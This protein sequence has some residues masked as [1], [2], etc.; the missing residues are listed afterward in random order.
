MTRRT[1]PAAMALGE[2][3][4]LVNS[5]REKK[6]ARGRRLGRTYKA[7]VANT[8]K[9][10]ILLARLSW[11]RDSMAMG[12]ANTKTSP[13]V[14]NALVEMTRGALAAPHDPSGGGTRAGL[15]CCQKKAGGKLE[16]GQQVLR[17]NGWRFDVPLE[18][19]RK[20]GREEP[21]DGVEQHGVPRVLEPHHPQREDPLVEEEDGQ[22]DEEVGDE[23]NEGIKQANLSHPLVS[24]PDRLAERTYLPG[25]PSIS[26]SDQQPRHASPC[27]T[28]QLHCVSARAMN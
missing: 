14:F 2:Q 11:R 16:Y 20:E 15:N 9:R 3:A 5:S 10:E 12:S 6:G 25:A 23:V 19:P 4:L 21:A 1:I 22:L 8:P 18:Q 24:S 27:Q 17:G 26:W 7:P 13:A 28:E